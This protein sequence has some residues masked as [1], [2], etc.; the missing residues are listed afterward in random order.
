M[1]G[2]SHKDVI[3][4]AKASGLGNADAH[5]QSNRQPKLVA[6]AFEEK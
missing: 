3:L 1:T 2:T 5:S 4:A 6:Y